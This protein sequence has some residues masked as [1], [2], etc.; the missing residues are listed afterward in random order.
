MNKNDLN[1]PGIL[2]CKV[3]L[4]GAYFKVMAFLRRWTGWR[5]YLS[6]VGR[7]LWPVSSLYIFMFSPLPGIATH[8]RLHMD[9]LWGG[10]EEKLKFILW[11]GPKFVHDKMGLGDWRSL[12]GA[13]GNL[14]GDWR[15]LEVNFM[16][17]HLQ[18]WREVAR[19]VR[20]EVGNVFKTKFCHN[21]C[22]GGQPLERIVPVSFN[23]ARVKDGLW[24]ICRSQKVLFNRKWNLLEQNIISLT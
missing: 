16:F 18:G 4:M 17:K 23:I 14:W 9:C 2:G 8:I 5:S 12:W 19:L 10:G 15:P 24:T 11:S 20:C 1:L 6:M 21:V 22:C 7:I 3:W 13:R